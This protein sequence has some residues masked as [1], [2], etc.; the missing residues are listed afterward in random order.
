MKPVGFARYLSRLASSQVTFASFIAEEKSYPGTEALLLPTMPASDGPTPFLPGC[1]EW[2]GT[3]T[4]ANTVWPAEESP[5]ASAVGVLPNTA[6]R[7][8][9]A[10][11]I[12]GPILSDRM[13]L[14]PLVAR[15]EQCAGISPWA[16]RSAIIL[17]PSAMPRGARKSPARVSLLQRGVSL[18][19]NPIGRS[20]RH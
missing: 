5:A 15:R 2:Q 6:I 11:R 1:V 12:D 16:M 9:P 18:N 14:V 19:I 3:Q 7:T 4:L 8:K 10:L 13:S 20:R 17:L